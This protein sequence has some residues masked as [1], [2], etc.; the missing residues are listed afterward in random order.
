MGLI[1][2]D[3]TVSRQLAAVLMPEG[4]ALFAR[5]KDHG[6]AEAALLVH[7]K[8]LYEH[9]PLTYDLASGQSEREH[10]TIAAARRGD[11]GHPGP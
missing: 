9:T 3:K 7:W 2:Q 1:K 6:L 4:A 5:V 10:P 8:A 11:G